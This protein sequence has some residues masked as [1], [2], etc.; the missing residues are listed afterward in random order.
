MQKL[1]RET[2]DACVALLPADVLRILRPDLTD[3]KIA[4]GGGF[5]RAVA[6]GET[7]NDIDLWSTGPR[8]ADEAMSAYAFARP[9]AAM[10]ETPQAYTFPGKPTVQFIR[11]WF[12]ASR[13]ELIASF[14]FTCCQVALWWDGSDWDS[15]CANDFYAACA[16]KKLRYTSP[17]RDEA[18][19]GSLMR[20][21][22]YNSRGWSIDAE[23][24][25]KVIG[26]AAEKMPM[27]AD[28]ER[29]LTSR[30]KAAVCHY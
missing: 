8:A 21:L 27:F 16:T 12:F 17:I 10:S 1:T 23:S 3:A 4:L 29:E 19:A 14:D 30:I 26:R 22:K 6:A 24:F 20:V 9:Q 11:R 28:R 18:P 25:A 2:I 13:E 15:V 7:P 5:I